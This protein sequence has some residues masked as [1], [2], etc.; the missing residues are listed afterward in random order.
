MT[1]KCGICTFDNAAL[2]PHCEM[3]STPKQLPAQVPPAPKQRPAQGPPQRQAQGPPQRQAPIQRQAPP[4][5]PPAPIQRQTH[6]PP[7]HKQSSPESVRYDQFIYDME[8]AI[9]ASEVEINENANKCLPRSVAKALNLPFDAVLKVLQTSASDEVKQQLKYGKVVSAIAFDTLSEK[10]NRRFTVFFD[11][12]GNHIIVSEHGRDTQMVCYIRVEVSGVSLDDLKSKWAYNSL[13][14]EA[15]IPN[16]ECLE[17]APEWCQI[18]MYNEMDS[19]IV[20]YVS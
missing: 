12:G 15:D 2:M 13:H 5:S 14:Y 18:N 6:S 10:Y 16:S 3:C 8:R 4:Q 17:K 19:D 20:S 7:E 9:H 1:W 11:L